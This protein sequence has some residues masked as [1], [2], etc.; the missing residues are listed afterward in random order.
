MNDTATSPSGKRSRFLVNTDTSQTGASIDRP[1]NQRNSMP[2]AT[3]SVSCRSNRTPSSPVLRFVRGVQLG[4]KPAAE[5]LQRRRCWAV[6][7][8]D[9][10]ISVREEVGPWQGGD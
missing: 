2:Q 10:V 8:P 5:F 4:P 7:R 6:P 1:L 3:C 9:Q